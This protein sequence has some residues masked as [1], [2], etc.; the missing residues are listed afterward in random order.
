MYSILSFSGRRGRP[1]TLLEKN[2]ELGKKIRTEDHWFFFQS[3]SRPSSVSNLAA[4]DQWRWP[5]QLH[6]HLGAPGCVDVGRSDWSCGSTSFY[7]W[8]QFY[9]SSST[10]PFYIAMIQERAWYNDTMMHDTISSLNISQRKSFESVV[11]K[12]MKQIFCRRIALTGLTIPRLR[13][14]MELSRTVFIG[15][16]ASPIWRLSFGYLSWDFFQE[17]FEQSDGSFFQKVL[18]SVH[19]TK[20]LAMILRTAWSG[21]VWDIYSPSFRTS[22]H[23]GYWEVVFSRIVWCLVVWAWRFS[24]AISSR[25]FED[26]H[27]KSSSPSWSRTESSATSGQTCCFFLFWVFRAY[28][29]LEIMRIKV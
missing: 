18:S 4:Q 5:L 1:V 22:Q 29:F 23:I 7:P 6:Q 27:P 24:T 17:D 15:R 16:P 25:L 11:E 14:F 28:F 13:F 26:I 2:K 20:R 8:C 3:P 10:S 9:M 21:L 12:R 19:T